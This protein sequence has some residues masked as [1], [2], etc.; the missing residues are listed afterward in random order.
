VLRPE[1]SS[2]KKARSSSA[3]KMSTFCCRITAV[4]TPP[5]LL[6]QAKNWAASYLDQVPDRSC[7]SQHLSTWQMTNEACL[8]VLLPRA[9]S[10]V[11]PRAQMRT[12]V[13]LRRSAA[14]C[15]T[16]AAS[17][18][19]SA[20]SLLPATIFGDP[21]HIY[22]L[23]TARLKP[24][25]ESIDSLT[26]VPPY[27]N[28]VSLSVM[29]RAKTVAFISEYS[30]SFTAAMRDGARSTAE[31]LGLKV[32]ADI[33]IKMLACNDGASCSK[34]AKDTLTKLIPPGGYDA[35]PDHHC[36]VCTSAD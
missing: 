6:R 32:V 2:P 17:R 31:D 29:K 18:T 1:P 10:F 4:A 11:H 33:G 25:P 19:S 34:P 5:M 30:Q 15:L 35:A 14:R 9:S 36:H 13:L 7:F 21:L 16:L 28:F 3:I 27:S 20:P 12:T 26:Y 22:A 8:Q 24:A 23:Q